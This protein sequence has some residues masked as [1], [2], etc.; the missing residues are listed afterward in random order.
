MRFRVV[1]LLFLS[2]LS[3]VEKI[4]H[5]REINSASIERLKVNENM[6][7]LENIAFFTEFNEKYKRYTPGS[8]FS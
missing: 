1:P 5:L 6:Q 8:H 3:V 2:T 4:S 7:I